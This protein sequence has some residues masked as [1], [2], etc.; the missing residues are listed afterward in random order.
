[1]EVTMKGRLNLA[2]SA[3]SL[4][5]ALVLFLT[6]ACQGQ[7]EQAALE[8]TGTPADTAPPASHFNLKGTVVD[9][10]DSPVV[11]A[12]IWVYEADTPKFIVQFIDGV[13]NPIGVT[14]N[15][16]HFEIE[17]E[18]SFLPASGEIKLTIQTSDLGS[19]ETPVTNDMGNLI[20]FVIPPEIEVF[21]IDQIVGKI[22]VREPAGSL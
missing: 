9:E 8:E 12:D 19:V 13:L 6:L 18:R 15:E 4:L 14:D 20:V 21:D 2:L 22:V 16:G 17:V 3:R 10:N 1:M 11:G 5:L 7:G